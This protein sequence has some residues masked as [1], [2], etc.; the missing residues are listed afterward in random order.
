MWAVRC[1]S[2]GGNYAY[3]IAIILDTQLQDDDTA[4]SRKLIKIDNNFVLF[5]FFFSLNILFWRITATNVCVSFA[6]EF[7]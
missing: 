4:P 6:N 1:A 7:I 3:V 5:P 2:A